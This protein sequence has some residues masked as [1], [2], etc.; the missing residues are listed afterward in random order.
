MQ[1]KWRRSWGRQQT[2]PDLGT[3]GRS[4]MKTAAKC[5]LPPLVAVGI[6]MGSMGIGHA[7]NAVLPTGGAIVNGN[8]T[9]TVNGSTMTINQYT[10]KMI[11]NWESFSIGSDGTV[12]F[13]QPDSRSVALNRVLGNDVSS[14]YGHLNATGQV[15][16]INPNGTLFSS[17]SQVNVG[18]LITSSLSISDSD[19]LA[20]NYKFSGSD[21]SGAVVNQ[22]T[23][24]AKSGG[25]V[26]LLGPQVRNE[27]VIVAQKGTVALGA[28]K[29]VTLDFNG[30]GLLNL[31]VDAAA[32]NASAA[33]HN[34]I[35]A[36]G[37]QV[38]MT[39]RAA[40]NLAGTVVNN[41]GIIQARSIDNKNG[42]IRLDG[43]TSGTV[44]NSGTLDASGRAA[45]QT[46]G[47]VKVL[48]EAVSI[49][50][51]AT[52]DVSGNR[53][54]GTALIGGNY[55]GKGPEQNAT[56]TTV[57][58]GA[59]ITADAINSGNG[60]KVVVWADD[61][62]VFNGTIS[63]RGGSQGGDGG[64][65]ETSGHRTLK[66]GDSAR[67][68]TLAAKGKNGN[69]LLDPADFTIAASG[70]D[71]TGATLSVNLAG[72][73]MTILSSMGGSGTNGDIIVNDRIE[74]TSPTTLTLS[75]YRDININNNIVGTGGGN[76]VLRADNTG[77]N[78]ASTGD[79]ALGAG[80]GTVNVFTPTDGSNAISLTGGDGTGNNITIYY[81][82]AGGYSGSQTSIASSGTLS[83]S[84]YLNKFTGKLMSYMLVNNITDLQNIE[85][86]RSG[87]YALGRD[88]DASATRNWITLSDDGINIASHGFVPLGPSWAFS[89]ILDGQGHTVDHLYIDRPGS[90]GLFYNI[91][92]GGIVR[93]LGL[94]NVDITA[95]ATQNGGVYIGG[96]TAELTNGTIENCYV[97]GRLQGTG[98]SLIFAGGLVGR[99]GYNSGPE[100]DSITKS[101]STADVT[102]NAEAGTVVVGGL[103]GYMSGHDANAAVLE[104][105]YS[106]GRVT[107]NYTGD[108]LPSGDQN[109]DAAVLYVGGLVGANGGLKLDAYNP[110]LP[111]TISQAYATG[112]VTVTV[113]GNGRVSEAHVGGLIGANTG[114]T[115]SQTYSTGRVSYNGDQTHVGGFAGSN[116]GTVSQSY[117]DKEKSGQSKGIGTDHSTGTSL[118][119]L[120]SAQT[121]AR[122]SF[123]GW[124]FAQDWYMI[125]GY[126][127]PFLR[128]EY[129]TRIAN[130]HQLQLMA[131]DPTA[132]YTLAA[133]LDLRGYAMAPNVGFVPV[134]NF[135]GIFDGQGHTINYLTI[136]DYGASDAVGLFGHAASGAA[137]HDVALAN[138]SVTGGAGND[139]VGIL[140]GAN[141]GSIYNV[142]TG[143][144]VSGSGSVGGVGGQNDG[145]LAASF[146]AANVS[147][148]AGTAGGLVGTNTGTIAE[149]YL[150]A[151]SRVN[152]SA[153]GPLA[154]S[155]S[156]TITAPTYS[157]VNWVNVGGNHYLAWTVAPDG[158]IG[159]YTPSQLQ[160]IQNYLAG[161][162][163][164]RADIDLVGLN[165]Q[166]IGTAADSFTGALSGSGYMISNL[167]I[168]N[169]GLEAIGLFGYTRG[170]TLDGL[171]LT[172]VN[173]AGDAGNLYVG[174]LVGYADGSGITNSTVSGAVSA[175]E[176]GSAVGGLAGYLAGGS[177]TLSHNAASVTADGA[178]S[179]VGGLAGYSSGSIAGSTNTGAVTASGDGSYVGGVAGNNAGGSIDSTYYPVLYYDYTV[180]DYVTKDAVALPSGNSG[181]VTASGANSYVGGVAGANSGHIT[182]QTGNSGAVTAQ[183][184]GSYVGG[185]AGSNDG[186]GVISTA[187]NTAD[188]TAGGENSRVGGV[189]GANSGTVSQTYFGRVN[190]VARLTAGGAGS[191]VGGLIGDNSGHLDNSY[192]F[193]VVRSLGASSRVGGVAG[194]NSG[195]IDSVYT[196]GAVYSLGADSKAGGLIG[197]NSSAA[198]IRAIWNPAVSG[199]ANG[200]GAGTAAGTALT[201][202]QMMNTANWA[203]WSYNNW[204]N[205]NGIWMTV[206]TWDDNYINF[207]DSFPFFPWQFGYTPEFSVGHVVDGGT[208]VTVGGYVQA[209]AQYLDGTYGVVFD[210]TK[211]IGA[212]G[213]FWLIS[214][215]YQ[216]PDMF[217]VS[218]QDYRA[219]T[220][221]YAFVKDLY[222]NTFYFEGPA[223]GA[224]HWSSN[225]YHS[226]YSGNPDIMFT[227]TREGLNSYLEDL[228]VD[229]N[230]RG[231]NIY[232]SFVDWA[233]P[234]YN[235][236]TSITA[237]GDI[238]LDNSAL[239][240]NP[241][242]PVDIWGGTGTMRSFGEFS[243]DQRFKAGGNITIIEPHNF[244]IQQHVQ[245]GGPRIEAGGDVTIKCGG[246]GVFINW[247]GPDAIKAG[248][249]T[250]VYA[251]DMLI[252]SADI[253]LFY[254][255]RR[256]DNAYTSGL[257][258]DSPSDELIYDTRG[259][260][261]GFVLWGYRDGDPVPA[262]GSG[263][264]YTASQTE[265]RPWLTPHFLAG[266]ATRQLA[267][268]TIQA[269][270][271]V[272]PG[273]AVDSATPDVRNGIL[274]V[275]IVDGGVALSADTDD[276]NKGK[277]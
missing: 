165:W 266:Q 135:S 163:R 18:S 139:Y 110:Y 270:N 76:L 242:N 258:Y 40:K 186:G 101:Y 50:G 19:F 217:L 142:F 25:Y 228:K 175:T 69:W 108:S 3:V 137:I 80:H 73:D 112:D 231:K 41:S 66:V 216:A 95:N 153:G 255:S 21:N 185:V 155:D 179:Y 119:G 44:V 214:P 254:R 97:T 63:A 34:L 246:D 8:G 11:A 146:S 89:G 14:I 122:S 227:V 2:R 233:N 268:G 178:N 42:V 200:V 93:N 247:D 225:I 99:V 232:W 176:T 61:K 47:T 157:G 211:T 199:Q 206:R 1:R 133:D 149:S 92:N 91:G 113:G 116:S 102:V 30:D 248:G 114:G 56:T 234:S 20:G 244:I 71:M 96:L 121:V 264:I 118:T 249:R 188:V 12:N 269:G 33:N 17:T 168:A 123:A 64:Q 35:Q 201:T 241:Y 117:W 210:S 235:D 53:G 213:L 215:Q 159:L 219:N 62:T 212:D 128:S 90:A 5:L 263:F 144:T 70:G 256:V 182:G 191:Y 129:S 183:G 274:Q 204:S 262:S 202:A 218:G 65:I 98:T 57:E 46:G 160:A 192:S 68:T 230:F 6:M 169:S 103:I 138:A 145:S 161:H 77:I 148:P 265:P 251:K 38:I 127:L 276:T 172:N 253:D 166:A 187:Y 208:G 222:K 54:G 82:P 195:S 83:R 194:D 125:D 28:G 143:G 9:I 271:A 236:A 260:L 189:A 32:V 78:N 226:Y 23:I 39:G 229:G 45:G 27:G 130:P 259:G 49:A 261:P 84:P 105:N 205:P 22:G 136:H 16:L 52:V 60:G 29:A 239:P 197:D 207:V 31:A 198:V 275:G 237:S 245:A 48:G 152:G 180:W 86:N 221:S 240:T 85:N 156:G 154:G 111:G 164:L 109:T 24:T 81:D 181:A 171:T 26:A 243:R 132:H 193:G 257:V 4:V 267:A 223:A 150:D 124:D 58:Q 36:D 115:I 272:W 126:T 13:I 51:G 238:V 94:T 252:T 250:L 59:T 174:G 158:T 7:G 131:L 87:V 170:A 120:T 88:I 10:A 100:T 43:G 67:V 277:E 55:Q 184:A 107:V 72:G 134:D 147:G 209:N 224:D 151:A 196:L 74:W 273:M 141:A 15:F 220:I 167:T 79:G 140:A 203:G 106:G 104:N 75:A 177:V 162:Y 173:I 37:G 190:D